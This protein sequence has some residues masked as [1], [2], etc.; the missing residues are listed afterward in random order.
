M[1]Q[2]NHGLLKHGLQF[3]RWTRQHDNPRSCSRTKAPRLDVKREAR[4]RAM[5]I[6]KH[7]RSLRHQGLN[8]HAFRNAAI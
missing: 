1:E 3:A 5:T 4:R 6:R 7:L 2:G 8:L